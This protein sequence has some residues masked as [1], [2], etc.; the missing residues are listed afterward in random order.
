MKKLLLALCAFGILGI[1]TWAEAKPP[2]K[3]NVRIVIGSRSTGGDTYQNSAIIANALNEKTGINFKVDAV[4]ASAGF[5]ALSR[6]KGNNTMMIFHDG[7]YLMNLYGVEGIPNIFDEYI[8]GPTI[9]VNPGEGYFAPK[10]SPY[11]T[12]EDII[13]AAGKGTKI[14]VAIQ[15]GSVS[16]IGYSAIKNAIKMKYPGSE[17]NLVAFK[18]G[19][20]AD[21]NQALFDGQV[22]LIA[23]SLQADEQYTRLPADDQKAMKLVW[24]LAR[25][26]MMDDVAEAGL[27]ET[28]LK[29]L[30]K[31]VEPNVI[32]DRGDGNNFTF[33]KEF[34]F[35][36]NKNMDPKAIEYMDQVLTEIYAEGHIQQIQKKSFF[37]PN[38]LPSQEAQARIW[39]KREVNKKIIDSIK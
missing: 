4:G 31:F 30:M 22:D 33:D 20:T 6:A 1:T 11:N 21:K 13:E 8:I 38:F 32:V 26:D 2:I 28:S 10:K 17:E 34:Y 7:A 9:A 36:Y 25:K 16:E 35:L 24:L 5:K 18:T 3:G 39:E 29:E 14:R 19:S 37:I 23:A 15:P 27:G 12:V